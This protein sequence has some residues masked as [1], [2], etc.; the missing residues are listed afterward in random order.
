MLDQ[1][2]KLLA[3]GQFLQLKAACKALLQRQP[4]AAL[5]KH[6]LGLLNAWEGDFEN[7]QS[8]LNPAIQ[9]ILNTEMPSANLSGLVERTK[10]LRRAGQ[11]ED[12][13]VPLLT[14]LLLSPLNPEALSEAAAWLRAQN[15][16][17]EAA[18][19]LR[20]LCRV[21]PNDADAFCDLGVSLLILGNPEA[22]IPELRQAASLRPSWHIPWRHLAMGLLQSSHHAAAADALR[23]CANLAPQDSVSLSQ[24]IFSLNY[25]PPNI[26]KDL[27]SLYKTFAERFDQEQPPPPLTWQSGERLKIGYV[28]GDFGEH[29]VAFFLEPLLEHHDRSAWE[30]FAYNNGKRSDATTQRLRTHAEHWREVAELSDDT[31]IAKVREDGIHVLVDLSG[32]TALNRLT[33]FGRRPAPIQVTMIGAMQTTGLPSM[34][35]RITDPFL[36]AGGENASHSETLVYM[37]SGAVVF[38][39]PEVAPDVASAPH[40][41]GAPFT[42]GCLNDPAKVT[43]PTL[44]VWAQI[45]KRSRYARLLFVR[46]PGNRI[47]E[48]LQALGIASDRLLERDYQPLCGFLKM[49]EEID[50]ALDPFPYNG[51]TVT[52]LGC[53]MGVVPIALLGE[54]PPA[55]AAAAVLHRLGLG[56]YV[57]RTPEE[58]VEK[59]VAL[60]DQPHALVELRR[61]LRERTH[62]AWCNGQKY[63]R[64]FEEKL[65]IAVASRL[66]TE[67]R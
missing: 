34:D 51:L 12:A 52:M 63:T 1:L 65:R 24:Y 15:R 54:A 6:V 8:L 2:K 23:M 32:H 46:R 9:Q 20:A 62:A 4:T 57:A 28:S 16:T 19:F 21:S 14:V 11:I 50:L 53:W 36:D 43:E 44:E 56:H 40:V 33:A 5:V 66:D 41:H 48:R 29:P 25:C 3:N 60:A 7:A 38:R 17:R 45:L 42:F 64:E 22:A 49:H 27:P 10:L 26:Q 61:D 39:P 58:Y 30:V 35:L 31:F 67:R 59:A 55:R 37:E 18:G 47:K 13:L